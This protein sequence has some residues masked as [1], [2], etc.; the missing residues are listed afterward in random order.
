MCASGALT[1]SIQDTYVYSRVHV[2]V[3]IHLQPHW[4][5]EHVCCLGIYNTVESRCHLISNK[6]T[7]TA[8][9][10]TVITTVIDSIT[11]EVGWYT[12]SVVTLKL[13]YG[14]LSYMYAGKRKINQIIAM[15]RADHASTMEG[16]LPG[17]AWVRGYVT[18]VL[19]PTLS[20]PISTV[21]WE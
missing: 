11:S 1:C 16:E 13:K 20:V 17:Q 5:H 4:P 8:C 10:I 15:L 3:A 6:L 18:T 12:I 14:A 9:L 2:H 7:D 21:H 19:P